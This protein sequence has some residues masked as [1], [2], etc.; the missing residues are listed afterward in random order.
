MTEN[1]AD[2]LEFRSITDWYEL[3]DVLGGI[4][5]YTDNPR[6]DIAQF[7][8]YLVDDGA[9]ATMWY[10]CFEGGKCM[11][12]AVLKKYRDDGLALL[13][14]VQSIIKGYGR[15]LIY[16]ILSRSRNIWWCADP[17]GGEGLVEYYRQFGLEEYFIKRSKWVEGRPEFAF[18]KVEDEEHRQVVLNTLAAA[19]MSG[20]AYKSGKIS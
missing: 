6:L 12:L 2:G 10:G 5:E 17:D 18:F 8:K 19:D 7:E 1:I 3:L 11:A 15:P 4:R 16:D 14:E 13:A 20:P 9:L